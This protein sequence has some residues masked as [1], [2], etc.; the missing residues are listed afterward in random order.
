MFLLKK[1]KQK[2]HTFC[3][4]RAFH[5]PKKIIYV[6]EKKM[7]KSYRNIDGF[8][9]YSIIKLQARRAWAMFRETGLD[10][11]SM[12]TVQ[13]HINNQTMIIYILGN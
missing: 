6:E 7:K 3:D 5:R 12:D 9:V 11:L 10:G 4:L 2:K 1:N 8:G 13:S